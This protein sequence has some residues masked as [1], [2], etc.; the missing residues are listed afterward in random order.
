ME[1]TS[2]SLWSRVIVM[3]IWKH[4]VFKDKHNVESDHTLESRDFGGN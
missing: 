4:G 1:Q 2:D 3:L